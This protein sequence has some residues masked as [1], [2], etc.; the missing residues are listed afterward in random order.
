MKEDIKILLRYVFNP[1]GFLE[2][3]ATGI[4]NL[5]KPMPFS[6]ILLL[7]SIGALLKYAKPKGYL[8]A[9]VFIIVA[10]FIQLNQI[11]KSGEHRAWDRKRRG[12]KSKK[13]L[14]RQEFE[15]GDLK[16]G[17]TNKIE[18]N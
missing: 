12:I 16:E 13:E 4:K 10:I 6:S 11:Y 8:I 18:K 9:A 17:E 2:T 3:I 15:K 14:L 1:K 5:F 7:L